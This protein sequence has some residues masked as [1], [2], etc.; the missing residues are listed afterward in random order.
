MKETAD[1]I[2]SYLPTL[3]LYEN[4][5]FTQSTVNYLQAKVEM[6]VDCLRKFNS[7]WHGDDRGANFGRFQASNVQSGRGRGVWSTHLRVFCTIRGAI[8]GSRANYG[9][10]V[11]LLESSTLH[12]Q[13]TRHQHCPALQGCIQQRGKQFICL[14]PRAILLKTF[15]F[16]QIPLPFA[17]V[18]IVHGWVYCRERNRDD[19][20][21]LEDF[22]VLFADCWKWI[23]ERSSVS[24][25]FFKIHSKWQWTVVGGRKN[26]FQ[27]LGLIGLLLFTFAQWYLLMFR[28][29]I[30]HQ[31]RKSVV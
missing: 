4:R 15:Y 27:R 3:R 13:T 17:W 20:S 9:R 26:L 19:E 30:N 2:F 18:D 6:I 31:D 24:K 28:N 11:T 12:H 14:R 16:V 1:S 23:K 21:S 22:F 8:S 10:E 5:V 7:L 29:M 25:T